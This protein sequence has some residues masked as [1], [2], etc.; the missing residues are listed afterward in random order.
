[1]KRID[2]QFLHL[3]NS[4]DVIQTSN[5]SE[6]EALATVRK[7]LKDTHET[8]KTSFGAWSG[9]LE[10]TCEE[11]SMGLKLAGVEAFV[12]VEAEMKAM[13][14]SV[15]AAMREALEHIDFGCGALKALT[16]DNSK[17]GLM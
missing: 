1:V 4:L 8:F 14:S 13:S 17:K 11:L 15:D 9:R 10:S 5:A 16:D 12:A 2:Q 3:Q 6:T 7:V